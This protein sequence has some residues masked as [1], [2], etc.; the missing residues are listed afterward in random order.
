MSPVPSW[1]VSW[2]IPAKLVTINLYLQVVDSLNDTLRRSHTSSA[3]GQGVSG[4]LLGRVEPGAVA[5]I[6]IE[7]L[8][9]VPP[10]DKQV[11]TER[12][13]R[14]K[15]EAG[16]NMYAIGYY[17]NH[18][19]EGFD[20]DVED[21]PV[22]NDYFPGSS[23]VVLLIKQFH[24]DIGIGG[25]FLREDCQIQREANLL[26]PLSRVKLIGGET[27]LTCV[28]EEAQPL[29]D[30]VVQSKMGVGTQLLAKENTVDRQPNAPSASAGLR[31]KAE[32][33]PRELRLRWSLLIG[34]LILALAIFTMILKKNNTTGSQI[35]AHLALN[36]LRE[37]NL[38][39]LNWDG[40]S[41][42]IKSAIE[43][44]LRIKDGSLEKEIILDR[45]HL[46]NSYF[47]YPNL[48]DDVNFRLSV[49]TAGGV[50]TESVLVVGPGRSNPVS[51]PQVADT[52]PTAPVTATTVRAT[53]R[54][55]GAKPSFASSARPRRPSDATISNKIKTRQV[56]PEST[57]LESSRT[58]PL[59]Q[60]RVASPGSAG[61]PLRGMGA[62][63]AIEASNK[64][65]ASPPSPIESVRV[66]QLL[67]PVPVPSE[68]AQSLE[69][70]ERV[71]SAV[72][73]RPAQTS[74][75]VI[76]IDYVAPRPLRR[77]APLVSSSLRSLA[78]PGT[79]IDVM[80]HIDAGG[81]VV[82]VEPLSTGNR[83]I[84]RLFSITAD[85]V[86]QW[87]FSPALR[88]NRAVP[89]EIVLQFQFGNTE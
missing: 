36:V 30:E 63:S 49:F 32:A 65:V 14:W 25:F 39:R 86:R 11:V 21:D 72:R 55:E 41:P 75:I 53:S 70:P 3:R 82:D 57:S 16:K 48:T 46:R 76:S 85:A 17:R 40:N 58:A 10:F 71:A 80:V 62:T 28:P 35:P 31:S 79:R 18:N 60:A 4:I 23:G 2:S 84:S 77:V 13:T 87:L 42:V 67:K 78:V 9:P 44:V 74:P 43:G 73:A 66:P 26:F 50:A 24:S 54:A 8:S 6:T 19:R 89:S 51:A 88:G 34:A 64:D 37:S 5:E 45:D 29:E 56:Q 27:T 12:L 81:K 33:G 47:L 68:M 52:M 83:L 38:L 22:A 7:G 59:E 61:G 20:F 1:Y 15:R 69:L